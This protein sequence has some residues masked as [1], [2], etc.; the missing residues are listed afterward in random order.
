MHMG[1]RWFIGFGGC[2]G[3]GLLSYRTRQPRTINHPR[4]PAAFTTASNFPRVS[5]QFVAVIPSYNPT[6]SARF[7]SPFFPVPVHPFPAIQI[8]L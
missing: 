1:F 8:L 4:P 3:T 6:S 5:S 7:A 2:L